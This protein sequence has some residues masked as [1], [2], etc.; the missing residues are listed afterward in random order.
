[1]MDFILSES[2]PSHRIALM[3]L[4]AWYYLKSLSAAISV[5]SRG[6]LAQALAARNTRANRAADAWR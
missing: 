1:M 6:K 5:G 3:Q 2:G 4:L